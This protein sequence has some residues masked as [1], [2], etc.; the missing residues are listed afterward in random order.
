MENYKEYCQPEWCRPQ[1]IW[2]TGE[3]TG[4]WTRDGERDVTLLASRSWSLPG[5]S[6]ATEIITIFVISGIRC[7]RGISSHTFSAKVN[8]YHHIQVHFYFCLFGLYSTQFHDWSTSQR[9]HKYKKCGIK[10]SCWCALLCR[11]GAQMLVVFFN[12]GA[13]AFKLNKSYEVWCKGYFL[14]CHLPQPLQYISVPL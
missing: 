9:I 4:R 2:T 10:R 3:V 6:S 1:A 13:K 7:Y 5:P 11:G 8:L 14:S 12:D